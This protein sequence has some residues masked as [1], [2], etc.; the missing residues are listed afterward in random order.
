MNDSE[1]LAIFG[2][3]KAVTEEPGNLFAWPIITDEDEAAALDVL[4]RGAMSGIE[5]TK[6]F[7][8]DFGRWMNVIRR[9]LRIA[10][11]RWAATNTGC[12]RRARRSDACS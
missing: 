3:S 2:G 8:E 5:V 10:T 7:E 9:S 6:Q 1:N 12:I 11:S 4:R